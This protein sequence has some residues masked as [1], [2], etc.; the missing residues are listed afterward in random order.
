MTAA[1]SEQDISRVLWIGYTT[2]DDA[3]T[4]GVY[5]PDEPWTYELSLNFGRPFQRVTYAVPF[6]KTDIRRPLTATI[7]YRERGRLFPR[8]P[9][10]LRFLLELPAAIRF[11][12]R[13]ARE[14]DPQVVQICGPNLPALLVWMTPRLWRVPKMCFIE[15]FWE[16]LLPDQPYLPV[17]L[18]TLLPL[19][20]RLVYRVFDGYCGTPSLDPAY[21][22]RRGMRRDR[23]HPWVQVIDL[24]ALA[25]LDAADAPPEVLSAPRPRIVSVG[26]LHPE[27]LSLDALETFLALAREGFPG[28][29]VLVGDGP[30][31]QDIERRAAA[32]GCTER[33]RITRQLPY[34]AAY[35]AMKACDL[36][37]A[38]MQGAALLEAMSAGLPIVAYDNE[39]HRAMLTDNVT[40]VLAPN[41]DPAAAAA[42]LAAL[43][44]DPE[45]AARLGAAAAAEVRRRFDP[46][47]VQQ[48]LAEPLRAV[49]RGKRA[50]AV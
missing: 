47:T 33:V 8:L 34:P 18:R 12:A 31:R 9:K 13:V 22:E 1:G 23:I 7:A 50:G 26:R 6:G 49:A 16:T 35:R 5:V 38:T 10:P 28:S 46:K 36:Y 29:L 42:A 27:K 43:V 44:A 14:A 15:A 17:P 20:Y 41:R 39:T 24:N 19:W 21:Y 4:K 30:L 25:A 2:H 40:A 11:L 3:V 32:A 45:R 37:L 48:V